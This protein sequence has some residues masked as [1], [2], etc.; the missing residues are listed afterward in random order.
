MFHKG[1]IQL[2]DERTPA[3]Y[4][5]L[6]AQGDAFLAISESW[7]RRKLLEFGFD[8][9]RIRRHPIG[10]DTRQIEFRTREPRG[11]H[12]GILTVARLHT[13]KGI[14]HGLRAVADLIARRRRVQVYYRIVGDGEEHERLIATAEALGSGGRSRSWARCP[15]PT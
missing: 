13:E 11:A 3:V 2:G 14:E 7:S 5:H 4:R 10:I 6:P 1:D 9:R 15:P 12:L 8:D